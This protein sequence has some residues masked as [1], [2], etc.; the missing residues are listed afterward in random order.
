MFAKKNNK[1]RPPVKM[2]PIKIPK[3]APLPSK[4]K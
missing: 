3:G 4:K 1:T 2:K